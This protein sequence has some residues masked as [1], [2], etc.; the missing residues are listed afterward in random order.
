VRTG[1]FPFFDDV[2]GEFRRVAAADIPHRVDHSGW[3]G[4]RVTGTERH[5]RLALDLILQ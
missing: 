4:Q 2:R 1:A 5:R 3:D